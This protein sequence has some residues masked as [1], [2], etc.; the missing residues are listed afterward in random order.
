MLINL[1]ALLHLLH[2]HCDLVFVADVEAGARGR[3]ELDACDPDFAE[4][5]VLESIAKPAIIKLNAAPVESTS[6]R[7]SDNNLAFGTV[8]DGQISWAVLSL[9]SLFVWVLK[10]RGVQLDLKGEENLRIVFYHQA[11]FVLAESGTFSHLG[12][13][14]QRLLIQTKPV[15]NIEV[16][17]DRL[18]FY[19]ELELEIDRSK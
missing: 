16:V 19:G 15:V 10:E 8:S 14:H 17:L 13:I 6:V 4:L 11:L 1:I 7:R 5:L 12:V 9:A 3:L 2:Y 18:I